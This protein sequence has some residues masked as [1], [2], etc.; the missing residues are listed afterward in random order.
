MAPAQQLET[1]VANIQK[2]SLDAAA[3]ASQQQRL[4]PYLSDYWMEIEE[5]GAPAFHRGM[6]LLDAFLRLEQ[7]CAA[8]T[9]K[10]L[11]NASRTLGGAL[12]EGLRTAVDGR[13]SAELVRT[14]R[15]YLNPR[16]RAFLCNPDI[17]DCVV[18]DHDRRATDLRQATAVPAHSA[19]GLPSRLEWRRSLNC[20][21]Q[22]SR[23]IE[24]LLA[25]VVEES[26][27]LPFHIWA[28]FVLEDSRAA[29]CCRLA[30]SVLPRRNPATR[31][32]RRGVDI[33][34]PGRCDRSFRQAASTARELA[35]Q[36]V[37]ENLDVRVW[38]PSRLGG[39]SM[40]GPSA[41][42]PIALAVLAR[43]A[44]RRIGVHE[45]G[46]AA[47]TG[48]VDAQ[49]K[50]HPVGGI[51]LK[52][53][54]VF[55]HNASGRSE[56]ITHVLMPK[57]NL[58]EARA[59]LSRRR[60]GKRTLTLVPVESF[61]QA[62]AR[63]VRDPFAPWLASLRDKRGSTVTVDVKQVV[64]A[65]AREGA[66]CV[67]L[68]SSAIEPSAARERRTIADAVAADLSRRRLKLED[69]GRSSPRSDGGDSI[70][71]AR[72]IPVPVP[73][74]GRASLR[75]WHDS[76][77][78]GSHVKHMA[79]QEWDAGGLL[80]VVTGVDLH[81]K[82]SAHQ[83]P[84]GLAPGGVADRFLTRPR[85]RALFVTGT[86]EWALYRDAF[87]RLLG[88]DVT[89]KT[90]GR[91][92]AGIFNRDRTPTTAWLPV[93]DQNDSAA[94]RRFFLK[95]GRFSWMETK[96]EPLSDSG[97]K[98]GGA[99]PL[100]LDEVI[101]SR[102]HA[103]EARGRVILV[104][105]GPG[106]GKSTLLQ[107]IIYQMLWD[108]GDDPLPRAVPWYLHAGALAHWINLEGWGE[109]RLQLVS[110]LEG[111]VVM[112][113]ALNEVAGC[114]WESMSVP[115][116]RIFQ[117]IRSNRN[118]VLVLFARPEIL[119]SGLLQYLGNRVRDFQLETFGMLP[120]EPADVT[121]YLG[122]DLEQF[123]RKFR[124]LLEPEELKKPL[125][126]ALMRMF[127]RHGSGPAPREVRLADLL[128]SAVTKIL[129]NNANQAQ[130]SHRKM[131]ITNRPGEYMA[132]VRFLLQVLSLQ[133][134]EQGGT[135]IG[136]IEAATT[137]KEFWRKRPDLRPLWPVKGRAGKP[138]LAY[139]AL[140]E[141]LG[142]S[143]IT[144]E[145]SKPTAKAANRLLAFLHESFRDQL[146]AEALAEG[147]QGDSPVAA[148]PNERWRAALRWARKGG[149][150]RRPILLLAEI[151]AKEIGEYPGPDH[152]EFL[153][154]AAEIAYELGETHGALQYLERCLAAC[155][156]ESPL[157]SKAA[158]LAG[159]IHRRHG[160]VP[161]SNRFFIDSLQ[162]ARSIHD[163]AAMI[164]ALDRLRVPQAR[165]VPAGTPLL[166]LDELSAAYEEAMAIM[167]RQGGATRSQLQGS[168]SIAGLYREMA[169][170]E[171][172]AGRAQPEQE[173]RARANA[174]FQEVYDTAKDSDDLGIRQLS[175]WALGALCYK[176]P[177]DDRIGQS[178]AGFLSLCDRSDHPDRWVL[179]ASMGRDYAAW[180]QAR[181]RISEVEAQLREALAAARRVQHN[182]E[183]RMVGGYLAVVCMR[184]GR[185]DEADTLERENLDLSRA[186]RIPGGILSAVFTL[187]QI[188][189]RAGDMEAFE[190]WCALSEREL[191]TYREYLNTHR[192]RIASV[193]GRILA[194]QREIEAGRPEAAL[195]LLQRLPS[196]EAYQRLELFQRVLVHLTSAVAA[197]RVG[198]NK[199]RVAELKEVRRLLGLREDAE[200]ALWGWERRQVKSLSI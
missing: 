99:A 34:G 198:D 104:L 51:G 127:H 97:Q 81:P 111:L 185:P 152:S 36:A 87:L 179:R 188:S 108:E 130:R 86:E 166:T 60:S 74:D 29:S 138:N 89:V 59:W 147:M 124:L 72:S 190:Q 55:D 172:E 58:A 180:L 68:A 67:V 142:T 6:V 49:G 47:V 98:V 176:N 137:L 196:E 114:E 94:L 65:A 44:G 22:E 40:D 15:R 167:S 154:E 129:E 197:K 24:A 64:A 63:V 112:M 79:T 149:V 13:E 88:D 184:L 1:L 9:K 165:E 133:A 125:T 168:F 161:E 192:G 5:H 8:K 156:P 66:R 109:V 107:R 158:H 57:G 4:L 62:V 91:S 141:A 144:H 28:L 155:P 33:L 84:A 45:A 73:V 193:R 20:S 12:R 2:G 103:G 80:L 157:R 25:S 164:A 105:G 19:S 119:K 48:A 85:N 61:D 56:P 191:D 145:V 121:R 174:L 93:L 151:T 18:P 171:K 41:G 143:G 76:V 83:L 69:L 148:G 96:V 182:E 175:H 78:A 162:A 177:A 189:L 110:Q 32:S 21:P 113:D 71:R 123:A 134:V 16:C 46:D 131:S 35:R 17:L 11:L 50:V 194:G 14:T 95:P 169:V 122:Q 181:G 92:Q 39:F 26:R 70:M 115:F 37:G 75:E 173:L 82:S 170:R 150:A 10:E 102:L 100:R 31:A 160:L 53:Q 159:E 120:P 136:L 52:L 132:D 199:F 178:F 139:S 146:A 30:V 135:Q 3:V 128:A 163:G 116:A 7:G 101:D 42:L 43:V 153:F 23:V 183:M 187:G 77:S 27:A 200:R 118:S 90:V 186:A 38:L 195:A 54:A 117:C 106:S 140:A 126:L